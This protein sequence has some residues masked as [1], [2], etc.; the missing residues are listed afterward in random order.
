M[1]SYNKPPL[2]AQEQ[3]QLLLDRG[4]ICNDTTRLES[5]LSS[6]GYYRL[7]AYWL[8]FE[9]CRLNES[10]RNHQFIQNTHFEKILA[11]DGFRGAIQLL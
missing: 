3:A 10:S 2:S 9:Q 4:L 7:S 1:N 6:I 5:Y 11:L 8:P